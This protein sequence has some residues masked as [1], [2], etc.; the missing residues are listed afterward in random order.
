M[1]T[2][3]QRL[4]P[5][6]SFLIIQPTLRWLRPT[7]LRPNQSCARCPFPVRQAVSAAKTEADMK[8]VEMLLTHERNRRRIQTSVRNR[9]TLQASRA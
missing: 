9:R 5:G 2:V 4:L 7:A 3:P 8:T 1:A 6:A